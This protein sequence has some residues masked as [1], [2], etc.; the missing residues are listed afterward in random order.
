MIC[1]KNIDMLYLDMWKDF[2]FKI[3]I[4]NI[5]TLFSSRPKKNKLTKKFKEIRS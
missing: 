5:V 4:D 3:G 1:K 2:H